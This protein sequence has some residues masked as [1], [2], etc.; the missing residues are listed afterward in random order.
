MAG[1]WIV[2]GKFCALIWAEFG[3]FGRILANFGRIFFFKIGGKILTAT[4]KPFTK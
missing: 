3:Q 1:I 2:A 4:I